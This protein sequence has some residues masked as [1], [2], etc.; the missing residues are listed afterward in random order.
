MLPAACGQVVC[1]ANGVF[2][3]K[4]R[5]LQVADPHAPGVAH[6]HHDEQ[7]SQENVEDLMSQLTALS[8]R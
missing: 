5:A 7:D 3:L 8:T 1:Y 6:G 2:D 4:D